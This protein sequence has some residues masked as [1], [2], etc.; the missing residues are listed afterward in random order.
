MAERQSWLQV[1]DRLIRVAS[2]AALGLALI[3]LLFVGAM[4]GDTG[5]ESAKA[6][7]FVFVGLASVLIIG[8]IVIAIEPG[9]I[10]R[11][12]PG[13]RLFGQ[14]VTRILTYSPA[15]LVGIVLLGIHEW[16]L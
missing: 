2:V 14:V 1:V 6:E 16:F 15:L 7:A 8:L 13:S 5:S 3:F 10:E 11:R 9:I 12:I 4:V